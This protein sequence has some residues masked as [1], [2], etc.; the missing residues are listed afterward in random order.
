ME[1]FFNEELNIEVAMAVSAIK[2][3]YTMHLYD[4]LGRD[5][6]LKLREKELIEDVPDQIGLWF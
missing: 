4:I 3:P 1:N 6:T 2:D 5:S